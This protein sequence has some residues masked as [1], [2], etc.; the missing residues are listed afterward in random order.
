MTGRLGL[1]SRARHREHLSFGRSGLGDWVGI[2]EGELRP[3]D[4]ALRPPWSVGAKPEG[5]QPLAVAQLPE[6]SLR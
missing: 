2:E 1:A 6:L 4:G 3:D 5:F